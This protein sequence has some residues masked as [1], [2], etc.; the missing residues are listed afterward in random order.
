M[1]EETMMIKQLLTAHTS[2]SSAR[3]RAGLAGLAAAACL[4]LLALVPA[5]AS[6]DF[7]VVSFTGSTIN[8]DGTPD[9]QAGSHPWESTTTFAFGTTTLANG[10]TVPDG[11]MKD[12][13]VGLPPGLI[14]DPNATPKCT[15][16]DLDNNN[17]SGASQVG[18]LMLN[19]TLDALEGPYPVYNMVP[20]TGVPAEFG[21]N[22][23]LLDA[24][25]DIKVRTGGDYGLDAT[26]SDIPTLLPLTGSSLT[27]WGVPADP[28]HD[29]QR[30]CPGVSGGC[31]A[32]V[33]PQPLLTM[34]TACGGPLTT[35]LTADS[36]QN[37]GQFVTASF[38]TTD[39][40][41]NPVGITGCG[42]LSFN[43]TIT[44]QPDTT[45]ADSPAGLSVDLHVPQAPDSPT[46][47]A[48]PALKNA[49][50]TLPPG[51]SL[52]PAS[53]DGLQSCSPTQFGP[54]NA[55]EPVCPDASKIGSVEID[56][57]LVSD[58]LTGGLYLGPQQSGNPL[59]VALYAAAEADG[60]LIKLVG[61][62]Q[63]NP[64]TGQLTTAFN[65][66]PQL[67]FTDFKLNFF[68]GP[69]AALD[70][71]E[72]CGTFTTT[73]DLQPW[74]SPGSGP[75]PTPSDSF[76][77]NSGCVSG[78]APTF[79]AGTINPQ[80]GAFSPFALT[81]SRSDTDQDISGLT[82]VLPPGMLAK[83][84]GVQECSDA[85]IAHAQGNTAL[86]EATNPSCPAGSQVGTASTF[87][88][89][90]PDPDFLPGNVYLT[91]PYN[92]A[93][94]GLVVIVPALAG[95]LDLGVVVVR[96][97]IS[98][99]PTDAHVTVTSDPLPTSLQGI[100]LRLR[101][102]DVLL[103]RPGFTVN[104]TSCN[105][106]QVTGTLVSAG[107]LSVNA[108]SPFQ[109]GGCQSLGFS[110]KLAID[111]SGR[112]KTRSGDH[113]TL[114]A[115]LS[116][117]A[118]Q[119]NLISARVTLPPS[120]ALDPNNSS[121]VCPFAVAQAVHGGAVGCPSS[122]IVGSASATTPLLSQPLTGPVYLVQGIRFGANGQQ[123]RTLPT[124]LV[125]LRGQLALD[126]RAST[127]VNGA[128]ELVTTFA[129]IPDVAVSSFTL[130][131]NGGSRGLLVITGRGRNICA[132]GQY[133]TA[134]L[135]AQ[136]GKQEH[137]TKK[138]ATPCG[139]AA[140]RSRKARGAAKRQ[141]RRAH[142]Q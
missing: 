54:T 142:R 55:S 138:M 104:P 28:S 46:S 77:I 129:S 72:S 67:P 19:D 64:S 27:L 4:L 47:L 34:P 106:L 15:I 3:R 2:A 41:G 100:P 56:S 32:G 108:A 45:V 91:G 61:T 112:G 109:V 24:T 110:P 26:L 103:N 128:G 65:N 97:T 117:G 140:D 10:N 58:P 126:L 94:Y 44:A 81:F 98:V 12:V 90:G 88:G 6:A 114:S 66:S 137:L 121:H 95:P 134:Q 116:E 33:A 48:T 68:G 139:R 135:D 83:L 141:L 113:P 123:I 59:S 131:I 86:A 17:C 120:L 71:P 9:T 43:P 75:D 70:T 31:S 82:V 30:T 124:L 51:V 80:A 63:V 74:S 52:N 20:P 73:S 111:L 78:F 105:P 102:L 57:P 36:W 87:S 29:S 35:T 40:S 22:L 1:S 96:Q 39:S 79:A 127:T 93:P 5:S 60:T 85:Q 49:T 62:T 130:T 42:Q 16:E 25:I 84:A 37:P 53:A 69:R 8:Q 136:S 132:A 99:D 115:D 119:A 89:P 38:Q 13:T 18:M 14:G 11:N 21:A 107:G 76:T 50:V 92:G 118:G 7:N 125:P 23:L 122:T 133:M 101:R